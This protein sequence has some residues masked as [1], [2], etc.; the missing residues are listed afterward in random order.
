MLPLGLKGS[1][2]FP[3]ERN[4]LELVH[5]RL[6]TGESGR[7]KDGGKKRFPFQTS[8]HQT[9][10]LIFHFSHQSKLI[11]SSH[12]GQL[13]VT[14]IFKAFLEWD[15]AEKNFPLPPRI[16]VFYW[17]LI[18]AFSSARICCLTGYKHFPTPNFLVM[19]KDL[20]IPGK[21]SLLKADCM[22]SPSSRRKTVL[23]FGVENTGKT[24][25][26]PKLLSV[27]FHHY[28]HHSK[29]A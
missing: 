17:L 27:P 2:F 7:Q 24:R 21:K 15:E 3:S 1:P 26:A 22:L 6:I 25:L 14:T 23:L 29:R 19:F 4:Y 10:L 28:H 20:F 13:E 11:H 16:A 18:V 5:L 8:S 12:I 9:V